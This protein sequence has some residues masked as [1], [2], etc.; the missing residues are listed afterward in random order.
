MVKKGSQLA[1]A[2]LLVATA[3]ASLR[4]PVK[5][6]PVVERET[7]GAEI[8]QFLGSEMA[9]HIRAIQ[10]LSP[11]PDQVL[12][13]GTT[14]EYTW[15][16]FMRAVGAYAEMAK[17][18]TLAERDLAKLVGQVG[19]WEHH[20]GSK[21]FSQ[22][23]AAQ[24]LRHFG[25]DLKTN[26]LWQG[27][28]EAERRAWRELL[29]MRRFYD[30]KTKNVIKLAENYL[31]VA[32][33]IAAIDYQLGILDDRKLLDELLDR[34]AQPFANGALYADDAP[35]TGRFDRY[36]NEYARFVWDAAEIAGRQDLLELLKPSLTAQMKLWWDLLQADGYGYAW[37]R[38]LGAIS[39]M[40]TMEIVGFVAAHAE[41]RPAPLTSL[42]TAYVLAWRWLRQDYRDAAH[43][44]SVF[45]FGRGNYR[46]ITRER[47]WQQTVGWFGKVADSY[48]KLMPV[49]ERE[50]VAEIATRLALPDVARF[51]YF[52]RGARN[53]GVWLM[54]QESLTFTLPLTTGTQ[55]GISDYLPAPHGLPGF[56]APVEQAFPA[57]VPFLELQD[58][59]VISATD[60]AD[61]IE[62]AADGRSLKAVW[63]RWALVGSKSGEF[64]SPPL[65]SEVVFR[66]DGAMLI[67]E[68]TLTASEALAIRRWWVAVPTTA[69]SV[70]QVQETMKWPFSSSG[71]QKGKPQFQDAPK[72]WR[73]ESADGVLEVVTPVADWAISES[74]IANGDAPLGRGARRAVPLY[75]LY[76]SHNLR[77]EAQRPLRWSIALRTLA[78]TRAE[79]SE[80]LKNREK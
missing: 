45:A 18:Q 39:Y 21:A 26:R 41:F 74:L 7:L 80:L 65:T 6:S 11:P 66:I 8:K 75:L 55:P 25:R 52:R 77:L 50:Q 53:A 27:L 76:E 12:G 19:L 14:G 70:Q 13:A 67:R 57:L 46:Y 78:T 51:E 2:L 79:G 38:S 63:R 60:G 28:T 54:R 15:G 33:R 31:G 22:L 17:Q 69:R 16:T 58:G 9:A 5:P 30:P 49:L 34:A 40:D 68:E 43:L 20:L 37:G 71:R 24:T 64:I 3:S 47:E 44:L 56:A 23:Y 1:L 72:R 48:M 35:P 29:D 73:L 61:E 42:A 36:S 32:A 10:S 4:P 59:R 62:P